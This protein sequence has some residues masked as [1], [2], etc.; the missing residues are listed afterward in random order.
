MTEVAQSSTAPVA[1]FRLAR[2]FE[3]KTLPD[4]NINTYI[5]LK[6]RYVFFRLCKVASSTITYH[7]QSIEL[8]GTHFESPHPNHRQ[9]SP[10]LS[11]YQLPDAQLEEIMRDPGWT[12][13]AF[14]R[15]PFSRLLSCY[16]HRIIAR[17]NSPSAKAYRRSTGDKEPPP[18]RRF[19]ENI[20]K[21]SSLEMERHWRVQSDDLLDGLVDLTF[22]GKVEQLDSDLAR[23]DRLLFGRTGARAPEPHEVDGAAMRTNADQKL[24][25]YYTDDVTAM[26]VKRFH[27]DFELFG[28]PTSLPA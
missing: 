9:M 7:L 21:Q 10:M 6:H 4:W 15:N 28:Y 26:V 1:P 14:V 18:F 19:V 20:C 11:P 25:E 3:R 23:L 16:L 8:A 2:V 17:P 12:R 24:S 27:R 13:F 22:V 5:S